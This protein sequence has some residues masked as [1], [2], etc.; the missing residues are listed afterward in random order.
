MAEEQPLEEE[1]EEELVDLEEEDTEEDDQEEVAEPEVDVRESQEFKD[2]LARA[3]KAEAELKT[4]KVK[5]APAPQEI[6]NALSAEDVDK[7]ILQSQGVSED[8]I[9]KLERIAQ[10]NG[11][12]VLA[13]QSDPIYIAMKQQKEAEEKNAK[14]SLGASK[15]SGQVKGRKTTATPNLKDEEHKE[16]WR[17]ANEA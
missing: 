1:L 9:E 16:L 13:A 8:L 14:A 10:I 17:K 5:K 4:L 2:V 15:G 11:T 7:K 12:S 6:N 3:K